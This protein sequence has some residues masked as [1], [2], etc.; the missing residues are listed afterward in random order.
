[1]EGFERTS[2]LQGAAALALWPPNA[3][4]HVALKALVDELAA[5]GDGAAGERRIGAADWR[6]WL[7]SEASEPLRQVQPAGV[8]DAPLWAQVALQG[9]PRTLLAGDLALPGLHY[10]LWVAS[11][12]SLVA[13][14]ED[15]DLR[16]GLELLWAVAWMADCVASAAALVTYDW[17]D[18]GLERRLAVPDD[19]E[20]E[21]LGAALAFSPSRLEQRGL[22]REVLAPLVRSAG[23][24]ALW[25]PLAAGS[26]GGLLVADPWR[27]TLAGL[28]RAQARVASSARLPELLD[29][30]GAAA[31][32]IAAE[33]ATDMDW[34]V[35][36]LDDSCL[37]AEADVDCHVLLSACVLPPR[38]EA[39]QAWEL[40]AAPLLEERF[41]RLTELAR[42][43]GAQH[44]LLAILGDGR[45]IGIAADHPSLQAGESCLPWILGLPELRLVGDALR[46]DPLGLP[47]VLERLPRPPWSGNRGFVDAVGEVRRQLEPPANQA[48][49]PK[50]GTE[51][52]L[53]R[54]R[55]MANRHPAP[56]HD[57]SGTCVEVSRWAGSQDPA[58]FRAPIG[59]P[60]SLLVRAPGR[61]FWVTCGDPEAVRHDLPVTLCEM[62]AF[63]LA[64]LAER[65]WPHLPEAV[66]GAEFVVTFRV[67]LG[68]AA[69]PVLAI[70]GAEDVARLVAGPA[71]IEAMCVG[72]NGADRMLVA[73]VLA[74]I[75][76]FTDAA[77][78]ALLDEVAPPGRATFIVLPREDPRARRMPDPPPTL[79]PREHRL[80][81]VAVAE[82]LTGQEQFLVLADEE[83]VRGLF[84]LVEV[85]EEALSARLAALSP[86]AVLELIE[87]HERAAIHSRAEA[88]GL[89]ARDALGEYGGRADTPHG[90]GHRDIVLR[91]LIERAAATPPAGERQLGAQE[92]ARLRAATELQLQWGSVA[93]A[94]RTGQVGGKVAIG[95]HVGVELR[96][97]GVLLDASERM[98]EQIQNAAPD[99]MLEEH[100]LWRDSPV[101]E[102]V[103]DAPFDLGE[104]PDLERVDAAMRAEWGVGL[105]QLLRLL[106]ALGVLAAPQPGEAGVATDTPEG[107]AGRLAA[108][109]GID[110]AIVA[111]AVGRL[112]LGPCEN[113]HAAGAGHRPWRPNRERSYLRQ[114]LVR[115]GDGRL[116]WSSE[117][118]AFCARYLHDLIQSGRLAGGPELKKAVGRFSQR[119][120][121]QFEAELEER[122]RQLGWGT[123]M[124]L[125]KLGGTR[126]ER[127]PGK[128]IGDI[129]VLAWSAAHSRIWLLDAKRLA[130]GLEARSMKREA[131]KLEEKA[132][133]HRERLQWVDARRDRLAA[134]IGDPAAAGWTL[135]AALVLDRPLAGAHLGE[136]PV[137]VWTF[138]ELPLKLVAAE[139]EGE[140]GAG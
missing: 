49:I 20:Y 82:A 124:R 5:D 73:A 2:L 93:D 30:L 85:I 70:G 63:W 90:V 18:H 68:A 74:C 37:L 117:H 24:A 110:P 54:A 28:V 76:G 27:L 77:Q 78:A 114:P 104:D 40:A 95:P 137:A 118:T 71:L 56:W 83:A 60:F 21:R 98:I 96:L 109:T 8:H 46:R 125:K 7:G 22:D 89:P 61:S 44:S 69:G 36:R 88:A 133:S 134:E 80:I 116:A 41:A 126:L 120:D 16:A 101:A 50:D 43:R 136:L 47:A 67:E 48:E 64:R 45:P 127:A 12:A 139:G 31:L 111:G 3:D 65:G 140:G 122:C 86:A 119:L 108:A 14:E 128:E 99:L 6:R 131:R 53:L 10:W 79:A 100:D 52:L 129:D 32:G 29:R 25:Q 94:L 33:A 1:L 91:A 39:E 42:E 121:R 51:H 123:R 38:A 113:Y 102:P 9:A 4:R 15:P 17:P 55:L 66:P 13:E 106:R 19:A 132:E 84:G 92:A 11:L 59:G 75:G 130:P 138:W 112:T 23:S 35:E 97:E 135:D 72:D 115:L 103:L 62:L 26:E 58:L 87:L 107:L 105:E 34:R 57:G 81:E